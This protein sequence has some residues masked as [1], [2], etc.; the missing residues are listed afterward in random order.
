MYKQVKE[1]YNMEKKSSATKGFAVLSAAMVVNKALSVIYFPFLLMII[2]DLGYGIYNAGY[3]VYGFIY[4]LTNSGFPVAISKLQ[5]ELT[6]HENYRDARRSFRAIRLLLMTYGFIMAV[7]TAVLAGKITTSLHYDRS[8]YVILALAPTMLFSAMSSSYRGFFNGNTTMKP[9]AMSQLIEQLINVVLSLLFALIFL[10]YGIEMACA[11][12]TVGTTL[13]SL[14]S[15]AYL[16]NSYRKSRHLMDKKTPPDIV[17]IRMKTLILRWLSYALP[18][19]FNS[20]VVWGGSLVDLWNTMQRLLVAGFSE[21]DAYIKFGVLSKYQR[22][23]AVPLAITTALYIAMIPSLSSALSLKDFKLL[24]SHISESFK[25]ALILSIPA[26]VGLAVLSKPVFMFLFSMK[27]VDGWYLMVEGSIVIVLMSIVQVQNGILQTLNKTR[28]GTMSMLTGIVVKIFINYFLIAI[29]SVAVIGAVIGT[30]VC[31]C[32]AIYLNIR[33]IRK[34]MPVQVVIKKHIGRPVVSSL[35]MG[36]S[37]WVVFQVFHAITGFAGEYA[38]N[39]ISLVIS[40]AAAV[41]VYGIA[42]LRLG[43]ITNEDLDNLPFGRRLK[44]ILP[45]KLMAYVK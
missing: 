26:A 5:A 7:L 35:L 16:A 36:A 44:R 4:V 33:H 11:G 32:L 18:I 2:G 43:G 31:Y 30:I 40:I 39:A 21:T 25:T 24:R 20:V 15:A 34:Y 17:P 38:G 41:A 8:Y 12:A 37:A 14:G 29:P 1:R 3:Q 22:L 28:L 23:I 9:T 13:G 27:Y 45:S 6:A 19:A 10:P 42:M